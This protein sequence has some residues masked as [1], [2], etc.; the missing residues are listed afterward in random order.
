LRTEKDKET[1][2]VLLNSLDYIDYSVKR[3][4]KGEKTIKKIE[5]AIIYNY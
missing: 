2:E 1:E 5:G 3:I 4:P